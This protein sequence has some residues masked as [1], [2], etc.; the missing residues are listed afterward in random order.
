MLAFL[1]DFTPQGKSLLRCY[2]SAIHL[3]TSTNECK[4]KN[5]SNN[6]TATAHDSQSWG[7]VIKQTSER[8]SICGLVKS[9]C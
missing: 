1:R 7:E 3:Y 8:L 4:S 5:Y 6:F 2:R 9:I